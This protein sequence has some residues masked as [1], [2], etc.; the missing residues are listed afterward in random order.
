MATVLDDRTVT[1]ESAPR[2]DLVP[3]ACALAV[4]ACTLALF[5][6]TARSIMAL[7]STSDTFAHGWFVLPL[8]LWLGWRVRSGLVAVRP[9]RADWRM[10]IPAMSSGGLWLVGNTAGVQVAE[11]LGLVLLLIFTLALV[12]GRDHARTLRFALAFLIFLAP[13]GA[14]LVPALM[15]LTADFTVAAI[16]LTGIPIYREG[17]YFSIPSG[18]WSVVEACSG[19]RYLIASLMLGTLYSGLYLHGGTARALFIALSLVVP[20]VAN[21]V[22][23]FGIVMLGHFSDMR[24]AAGADHLVYGWVFFGIVMF[25]LFAIGARFP[26]SWQRS[27]PSG[28]VVRQMV[29]PRERVERGRPTLPRSALAAVAA[30]ALAAAFPAWAL[31]MERATIA[32]SSIDASAF[33]PASVATPGTGEAAR[34]QSGWAPRFVGQDAELVGVMDV[35]GVPIVARAFVYAEQRQGKELIG[36]ANVLVADDERWRVVASDVRGVSNGAGEPVM[37]VSGA[38]LDGPAERLLVW[39]WNEVGGHHT[40][41]PVRGKLHELVARLRLDPRPS[42]GYVLSVD[43]DAPGAADAL[44]AAALRIRELP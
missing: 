5:A 34:L 31:V 19:I 8:S 42:V 33:L 35:A 40:S 38:T 20:I 21:G 17:L 11:Q 22:R 39:R 15:E 13:V 30:F 41:D 29:E 26:P 1:A 23:A 16:R 6:P 14:E 43:A 9:Y 44:R 24:L 25:C 37:Q 12:L 3:V 18:D 10:L 27:G 4:G 36:F 7:W 32:P 28:S 2:T